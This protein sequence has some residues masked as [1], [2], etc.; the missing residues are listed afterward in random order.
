MVLPLGKQL[1]VTGNVLTAELKS[2]NFLLNQQLTDQSI[3]EIAGQK[4]DLRETSE[5]KH[6]KNPPRRGGFFDFLTIFSFLLP[7]ADS[8][9]ISQ[10]LLKFP[11]GQQKQLYLTDQ[12]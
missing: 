3:A 5:A 8:Y 12:N 7:P 10:K 2:L 1:K 6:T 9:R 11:R 4:E